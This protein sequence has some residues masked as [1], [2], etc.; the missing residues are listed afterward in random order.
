MSRNTNRGLLIAIATLVLALMVSATHA[1]ELTAYSEVV[2]PLLQ[3]AFD[4]T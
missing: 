2:Q 4:A 3:N 1:G